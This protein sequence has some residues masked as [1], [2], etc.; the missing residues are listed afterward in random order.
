LN[1]KYCEVPL[2]L[3]F[4]FAAPASG[5]S[6]HLLGGPTFAYQTGCNAE[7]T[8]TLDCEDITVGTDSEVTETDYGVM[9]GGG[10]DFR[11]SNGRTFVLGA[12]YNMGMAEVFK[13]LGHKNRTISVI[14]GLGF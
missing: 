10:A 14:V 11:M 6:F 7:T 9:V 13:D 3:R 2:L 12:R 5:P 1:V 4:N 8:E